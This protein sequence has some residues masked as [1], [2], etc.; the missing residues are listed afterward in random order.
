MFGGECAFARVSGRARPRR[1][2]WGVL[3]PC[4][5]AEALESDSLGLAFL[6]CVLGPPRQ[7]PSL[8]RASPTKIAE[9]HTTVITELDAASFEAALY[10]F[11]V[12]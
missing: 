3:M 10:A 9:S 12:D 8:G 11:E 6:R 4:L 7:Q 1:D 2:L 5:D